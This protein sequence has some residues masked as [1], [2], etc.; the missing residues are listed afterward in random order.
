MLGRL[1]S[2]F[3]GPQPAGPS[4]LLKSFSPAEQTISRQDVTA[5]QGEW[6]IEAA[7]TTTVRLYEVPNPTS[8]SAS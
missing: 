4:Q 7:G 6:I 1:L 8:N 2:L 5:A 3:R